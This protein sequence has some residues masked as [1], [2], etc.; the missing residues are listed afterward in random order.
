MFNC[1]FST[2][3]MAAASTTQSNHEGTAL[4]RMIN[5]TQKDY[6]AS[7]CMEDYVA[8]QKRT[9]NSRQQSSSPSPI[10]TYFKSKLNSIFSKKVVVL[11]CF[12][13]LLM[14]CYKFYQTNARFLLRHYAN[15][16]VTEKLGDCLR[17]RSFVKC[18]ARLLV[19]HQEF[20]SMKTNGPQVFLLKVSLT[21]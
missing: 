6:Q 3:T 15:S 11:A 20:N 1:Y 7:D 16:N 18:L 12:Q 9:S 21:G 10:C 5:L 13:F 4:T 2:Y 8:I 19:R 14:I 17:P